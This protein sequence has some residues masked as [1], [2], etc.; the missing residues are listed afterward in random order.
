MFST[1]KLALAV[2]AIFLAVGLMMRSQEP[3]QAPKPVESAA[4][5]MDAHIGRAVA[6][7]SLPDCRGK[8]HSLADLADRRI[9]VVVFLGAECPLAQLYAPRLAAL[10]R[11]YEPRGV[12]FL[13]I[14]AN[15]Q[16]SLADIAAF[17]RTHRFPFPILKDPDHAVADLFGA[18][19]TPEAFVLDDRRVVRYWG[20][21][22]DQY[23]IGIRGDQPQHRH[24]AE[25]LDDLLGDRPVARPVVASVGCR[26][27]R[28]PRG[29]PKGD[30]TYSRH[31]RPLLEKRCVEC[32]RPGEIAPFA[33]TDY[34]DVVAWS[35]MIREVVDDGR[36]PPWF[37]S[38]AFGHFKNDAR[39]TFDE[40]RLLDAWINNGCPEGES[41]DDDPAPKFLP[42][43]RIPQPDLVVSMT[44]EPHPV[45]A[46]GEV[47]YE[48]FLVDPGFT[49]D[50]FLQ[51]AEVRPGNRAVVHHAL[52][53]LVPP[54]DT[55]TRFD[56]LGA[57]LDYAPG[58]PPMILPEGTALRVPAGSKFL[59][60][61][62]YTPNGSPQQ[63][64][65]RLGFVFADP[66][67]VRSHVQGAAV[68]NPSIDIPPG[69]AAYRLSAEHVF[70]DD[71]RLLSLSPHMHL[72]GKS[73]RIEACFPNGRRE[74]LL[75][76]PRYDFN[77]QL[78][79]DFAEPKPLPSGT[80]L[81]CTARYD[82]SSSNPANPDAT[83]AVVWGDQTWNEMLI[84][85]VSYV[86]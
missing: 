71:V 78:R 44:E 32:H 65:T 5:E 2:V 19:R 74:V 14:N 67:S 83:K 38:P 16:D 33:L 64:R 42:G 63:D 15:A 79:Y 77:W 73:F 81:V 50:K 36:M 53:A 66:R 57:L 52:V 30:V 43:W 40:K 22:D 3:L 28:I 24:L 13:S 37:A 56:T 61:M 7:F 39:M 69:A 10:F 1:A 60:Q 18:V 25:A 48:Y 34:R 17:V 45:P 21:I 29:V 26:I 86:R 47:D 58:M 46:E 4:A 49:E 6:D 55:R 59:F 9:V 85:F 72:R 27:G 41:A 80:R 31:I 82:N 62:H 8:T 20:R 11:E 23:S 76:V 75:D 51:A 70:S 35:S 84:G 54:G 68:M 12:G